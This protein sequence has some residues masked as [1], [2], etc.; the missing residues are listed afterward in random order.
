LTLQ[1]WPMGYKL[2]ALDL[3]G[4]TISTDLKISDQNREAIEKVIAAG[5]HVAII[6]GKMFS[7]SLPIAYSVPGVHYLFASNGANIYD[8]IG[9]EDLASY[10]MAN[11]HVEKIV[12]LIKRYGLDFRLYTKNSM[13]ALE[14]T[15]LVQE[16]RDSYPDLPVHIVEHIPPDETYYKFY[17]RGS[18][19]LLLKLS[20]D[21]KQFP[22]QYHASDIFNLEITSE[23]AN[24]GEALRFLK[25]SLHV[26]TSEVV[27]IGN[28]DNDLPM[29]H[30]AGF[31]VAVANAPDYVKSQAN[32]VTKDCTEH[33]VAHALN[34]LFPI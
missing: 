17:A 4:T 32:L 23:N 5:T 9:K 15:P 22:V 21:L 7:A 12:Q 34:Q 13:F 3:D 31:T 16:I 18:Q 19:E 33:G 26:D 25:Q 14:E 24:K 11:E 10:P 28:H 6:T 27:A 29:F 1:G 30:E 20:E 8:L 2:L